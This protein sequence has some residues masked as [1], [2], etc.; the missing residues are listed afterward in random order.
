MNIES[1][2][3]KLE[4]AKNFI[5]RYKVLIFVI[6]VVI[7]FSYMAFN[8]SRYSNAEPTALQIDDKKTSIKVVKLDEKSIEK[9][10]EL[11]GKNISIESL[12]NNGRA[13]PF[14]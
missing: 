4:P 5:T 10:K 2:I 9:I 1:F 8:I 3:E 7:V 6:T 11:Q 12:F 13:N 14:E